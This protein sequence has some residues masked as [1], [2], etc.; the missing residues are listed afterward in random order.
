MGCYIVLV[1]GKVHTLARATQ[2]RDFSG[3]LF[4]KIT[5]TDIDAL[6]E[7][8][9]KKYVLIEA[10]F[11]DTQVPFGQNL[12]LERLCDDLQKI[13][14]TLLIIARHNFGVDMEIDFSICRVD[15]YRYKRE[16]HSCT[17]NVRQLIER[18]LEA[19]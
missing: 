9:D 7:Y 8:K 17:A 10:K 16:W 19:K 2:A 3:L 14:P 11:G 6:I 12:A 5:P 15:K 4:G 13:K 18:F 1:A